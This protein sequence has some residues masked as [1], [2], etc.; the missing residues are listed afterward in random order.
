MR[1]LTR[2]ALLLVFF[3][4]VSLAAAQ[5][6]P[7]AAAYA[8]PD[9]YRQA[10]E[11]SEAVALSREALFIAETTRDKALSVLVPTFSSFGGHTQYRRHQKKGP[12]DALIQPDRSTA[13]GVRFDQ[14]FT[15]NGRELTALGASEKNI[16]KSRYDLEAAKADFLIWVAGAYFDILKVRTA[17]AIA[18]ADLK[19]LATHREAVRTRL[20]LGE[21]AKTDLYRTEAELSKTKSDLERARNSLALARAVLADHLELPETFSLIEDPGGPAS[22]TERPLAAYIGD[23][24]QN[25]P[26]IRAQEYQV[27]VAEDQVR[28]TVGD[29]WPSVSLE[30]VYQ[31]YD[32]HPRTDTMNAESAWVGVNVNFVLYDGGLRSAEVREARAVHRQAALVLEELKKRVDVEV[33]RAFL[34]LKTRYGVISS[35]TDQ[36]QYARENYTAVTRQFNH[37]L[38]NSVDVMD[39]NTLLVTSEVDLANVRYEYRLADIRLVYTTGLLLAETGCIPNQE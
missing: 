9:L 25:R 30:G 11:R 36:L 13:W 8:L 17:V 33:T 12:M 15:L 4:A 3:G 20:S 34:D 14:S 39:A 35:R 23:A 24:F 16:E 38:A 37:G 29:F 31:R 28:I 7:Q 19:R 2:A 32:Q 21:V 22:L 27:A 5:E 10:L 1:T 18:E 6:K 26:E